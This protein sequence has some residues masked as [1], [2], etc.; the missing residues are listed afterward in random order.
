MLP[1][2]IAPLIVVHKSLSF[3]THQ[4]ANVF[5]RFQVRTVEL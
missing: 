1:P 5:L 3:P 2:N 4:S